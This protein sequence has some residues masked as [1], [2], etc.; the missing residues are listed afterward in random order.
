MKTLILIFACLWVASGAFADEV[1]LEKQLEGLSLPSNQIPV[2][3]SAE[4]L[5]SV[6]PRYVVIDRRSEVYLGGGNNFHADGYLN[7]SQFD[8]GYRFH[9]NSKWSITAE[10]S[11]VFNSLSDAGNRLLALQGILP[12]A[13]YVKYRADLLA[14]Y[15]LFYGKFRLSLDTVFYFDQYLALGPGWVVTSGG[16][17]AAGVGDIGFVFWMGKRFN[18]QLGVKDF[19]YSQHRIVSTSTVNDIVGHLD[20]GVLL[21][22]WEN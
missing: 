11:M 7:S 9:L 19:Y 21:G 15:N 2:P 8:L 6:Q 10:G 20:F 1:S 18:A 16:G 12:D 3:V 13:G 14:G 5:Y 4:Q 17:S 22:G